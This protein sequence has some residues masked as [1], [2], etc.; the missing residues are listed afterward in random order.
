MLMAL[1]LTSSLLLAGQ[2]LTHTPQPVQSSGATCTVSSMPGKSL[3]LGSRERNPSGADF[4][5]AGS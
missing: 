4:S 3:P 2:M 5:T 1:C